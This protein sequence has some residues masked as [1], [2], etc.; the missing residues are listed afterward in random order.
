MGK[1]N[2]L[3]RSEARTAAPGL[4]PVDQKLI[5]LA[6]KRMSMEEISHEMGG[7]LTPAECGARISAIIEARDWLSTLD[8]KR[9]ILDDMAFMVDKLKQQV[10]AA[11]W[12]T[13]DDANTYRAA[14]KDTLDMID[15]V[16]L[17]DE[18]QMMRISEVHARVM[19]GAIRLGYERA[20]FELPKRYDISEQEA[21]EAIE[22]AI[23]VAF[24]TLI[25]G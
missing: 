21:F 6:G 25:D 14:L 5:R 2:K 1:D 20:V 17:Q 12:L 24:E 8:Q 18:A 15:N 23:P 13:K 9:L 7:I 3:A 10:E 4:G 16:T 11:E 22:A 19:A